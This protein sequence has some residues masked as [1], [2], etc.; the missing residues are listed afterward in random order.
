[1]KQKPEEP[2][3]TVPDLVNSDP[4]TAQRELNLLGARIKVKVHKESARKQHKSIRGPLNTA[5]LGDLLFT[6][7]TMWPVGQGRVDQ[8]D[9]PAGAEIAPGDTVRLYVV[10]PGDR[11][12]LAILFF[13]TIVVITLLTMSILGIDKQDIG[14]FLFGWIF[15]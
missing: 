14:H 5:G 3:L 11:D 6:R 8:S 2:I 9:P 13:F 4:A 7:G 15:D 10:Y 1:M 12:R